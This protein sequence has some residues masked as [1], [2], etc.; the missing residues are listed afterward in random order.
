MNDFQE[1][2]FTTIVKTFDDV[3]KTFLKHLFVCWEDIC[4]DHRVLK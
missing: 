3:L 1:N 2:V 4:G